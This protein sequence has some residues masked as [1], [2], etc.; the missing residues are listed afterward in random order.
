MDEAPAHPPPALR[1]IAAD[2]DDISRH[3]QISEG[4]VEPD[5]LLSLVSNLRLDNEKINIAV[6]TGLSARMRAKQNHLRFRSSR[7]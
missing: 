1:V 7:R 3:A 6:G 5:R 2:N 4:A